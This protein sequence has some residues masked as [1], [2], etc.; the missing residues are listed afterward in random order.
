L[1]R[2]QAGEGSGINYTTDTTLFPEISFFLETYDTENQFINN[3]TTSDFII[4]ENGEARDVQMLERLEPG[5]QV[6]F[7]S[8][9]LR[10]GQPVRLV[11]HTSSKLF[12][13]SKHGLKTSQ[14]TAR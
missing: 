6:I 2:F 13:R 9:Q 8:M 1:L 12:W 7:A 3:L 4:L 14:K 10:S 5:L 11:I